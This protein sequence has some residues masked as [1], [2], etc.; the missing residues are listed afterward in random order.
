MKGRVVS[1]IAAALFV[2]TLIFPCVDAGAVEE[3]E[4]ETLPVEYSEF[5]GLLPDEVVDKLPDKVFSESADDIRIAAD[6]I[7]NPANLLGI[8]IDSFGSSL[9]SVIPTLALLLGI[10]IIS[11]ACYTLSTSFGSGL[12]KTVEFCSRLCIYSAIAGISVSSLSRLQDYFSSLF[13][14]VASFVPL[15]CA[16]Y[17]MGGNLTVA[18]SSSATLTFILTVCQFICTYTVI[19]IFC[20]CLSLSLLSAFDGVV[21]LAGA[22]VGGIIKKW[23]SSALGFIMVILTSSLAAQT[24]IASKADNMAMKGA[25]FAVSSFV[26]VSGGTVS[27]TLGTLA[28]SVEMLRGSVGVIGIFVI[29]LMLIPLIVE[30]AAMR[31]VYGIAEF[32]AGMLSCN[33]EKQLLSDIGGLYGYLEGIA[34]LCSVVFVIAFAIFINT[35]TPFS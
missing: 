20:I 6:Q 23:Y 4:E 16:L 22:S 30:L 2:L 24:I 34:A 7:S 8:L 11:A 1:K 14:A 28:S 27:S 19:P 10:V 21:K 13:A 31:L 9:R 26:P 5:I 35:A 32:T 33:G 17:A 18:A 12:G 3:Y 15:S 25:K 29:I